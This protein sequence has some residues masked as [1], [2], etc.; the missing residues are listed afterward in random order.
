MTAGSGAG[1][2]LLP[3][4]DQGPGYLLALERWLL[5]REQALLSNKNLRCA[6]LS[7]FGTMQLLALPQSPIILKGLVRAAGL[8]REDGKFFTDERQEGETPPGFGHFLSLAPRDFMANTPHAATAS[9]GTGF[10]HVFSSPTA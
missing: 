8:P 5:G 10:S 6:L 3:V 7:E 1:V 4:V 2:V 9:S